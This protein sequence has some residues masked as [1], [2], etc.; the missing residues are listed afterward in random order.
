MR[1]SSV[2]AAFSSTNGRRPRRG[3][4][5]ALVERARL[6]RR[7]T[8]T[9]HLDPRRGAA[10][11]SP[12]PSTRGL[13]SRMAATTRAHARPRPARR[14]GRRAALVRAGL[15]VDVERWRRGPRRPAC[16]QREHLR[17]RAARP[18]VEALAHHAAALR[19]PR[20]RPSGSGWSRP[21]PPRAPASSARAHPARVVRRPSDRLGRAQSPMQALA[22]TRPAS[23]GSRSSAASPTPDVADGH[24]QLAH[25]RHR[26]AALG[27]AVELG[28]H[29]AG[30]A[31]RPW[32][33]R[34]PGRAPFE[35]DGGVQHEQRLVRRA[36]HLAPGHARHLGQL[37]HQVALGVQAAGGV[38]QHG[39]VAAAARRAQRRR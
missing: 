10:A 12:R 26:D 29:E 21:A 37:R 9:R 28:E 24:A 19:R 4:D 11:R 15:E 7:A 34:G 30:D 6:R 23:K 18:P 27:R 2:S 35:P 14:A 5:E 16:A 31:R 3:D 32:R 20:S 13:G 39:V 36:R 17:V 25:H 22:R 1:P 8:P 33:T 38:H